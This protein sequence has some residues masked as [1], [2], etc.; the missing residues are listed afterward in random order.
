MK[1]S[2][3]R[4]LSCLL[5]GFL[6][7]LSQVN[8]TPVFADESNLSLT[9]EGP[10]SIILLNQEESR[11]ITAGEDLTLEAGTEIGLRFIPEEGAELSEVLVNGTSQDVASMQ[12]DGL[13]LTM[14]EDRMEISARFSEVMAEDT[15]PEADPAEE[16]SP[17]EPEE[18]EETISA[19]ELKDAELTEAEEITQEEFDTLHQARSVEM[20]EQQDTE[21]L[22]TEA[23]GTKI[24]SINVRWI[25]PQDTTDLMIITPGNNDEFKVRMRLSASLSGTHPYE[26]G[27]ISIA[28]PKVVWRDR[29]GNPT[30][31]M[32]LSVPEAPDTRATFSY[33]ETEDSYI[34]TNTKKLPAAC[35]FYFEF[36][37]QD[38]TPSQIKDLATGYKTDE[39]FG[40][41]TVITDEG[42]VLGMSSNRIQADMDSKAR[43]THAVKRSNNASKTWVS[44]WPAELKPEHEEDYFYVDWYT[45]ASVS[46]NQRYDIYIKDV[47]PEDDPY[48]TVFLGYQVG[49]KVTKGAPSAEDKGVLIQADTFQE[50]GYG[51][52]CHFFMAYPKENFR[53]TGTYPV[54]N[55]VTYSLES[56]DDRETTTASASAQDVFIVRPFPVP[57]GHFDVNKSGVGN[58]YSFAINELLQ[59]TD[60]D[61]EYSVDSIG[62]GMPWTRDSLDSGELTNPDNYGHK[63]YTMTTSDDRVFFNEKINGVYSEQARLTSS[64]DYEFKSLKVN[65]PQI[66]DY[67]EAASNTWGYKESSSSG[68][69]DVVWGAISAGDYGY[70]PYTNDQDV[71]N[72]EIWGKTEMDGELVQYA[73]ISWKDPSSSHAMNG[74]TLSGTTVTF[75]EGVV[76]YEA[77][78]TTTVDAT[79]WNMHPMITLHPTEKVKSQL[80]S[81]YDSEVTPKTTL[82][83][84]AGLDVDTEM[85]DVDTGMDGH[86]LTIRREDNTTTGVDT[87][88]AAA[89]AV[90]PQKTLESQANDT[91][92]QVTHLKYKVT[93]DEQSNLTTMDQ[94]N[95]A[96]GLGLIARRTEGVFYDLL[97]KGVEADT[98]SIQL[99]KGDTITKIS[100]IRDY[101]G[102]GRTLLMVEAK[103]TPQPRYRSKYSSPATA[104]GLEGYCDTLQMT[105][106]AVYSWEDMTVHGRDIINVAGF[107]SCNGGL[108][109]MEGFQG[110]YGN[111]PT[112]GR[113][114]TSRSALAGVE[115]V[116]KDLNSDNDDPAFVFCRAASNIHSD[117][118]AATG[119]TKS[120]SV[121]HD[122]L[123]GSGLD[124]NYPKNVYENGFYT[125]RLRLANDD[126]TTSRN[127]V[128][129]D[130][131]ENWTKLEDRDIGDETWKGTLLSVD[132]SPLRDA[133]V[134]PVVY[135]STQDLELNDSQNTDDLDLADTSK[136]QKLTD[137]TELTAVRC[138]AFDC[139]KA[140]DGGEFVLEPNAAISMYMEM[141]APESRYEDG[142]EYDTFLEEGKTEGEEAGFY[143]G[144]HAYNAASV[145]MS[146]TATG[147]TEPNYVVFTGYTKVGLIPF[148]CEVEKVWED[149]DNRDGKRPESI[150][151]S[152]KEGNREVAQFD[153]NDANS[154]KHVIEKLVPFNKDGTPK[155]WTFEESTGEGKAIDGYSLSITR[156]NIDE[157]GSAGAETETKGVKFVL[158]NTHEPE[159]IR[160]EGDKKWVNDSEGTRPERIK[161]TLLKNGKPDQIKYVTA[162]DNWHYSFDLFKYENGQEIQWEIQE[163]YVPGYVSDVN[164]T[165]V[166]NTWH[167]YGDLKVSK[168]L[169]NATD[170]AAEKGEFTFR[171]ELFRADGTTPEAGTFDYETSDNK[172]G[173]ISPGDTF[174][175]KG[176]E[177]IV[178]R[179]IPSETRYVI[180][181]TRTSGFAL[182]GTVNDKGEIQAGK[183]KE[184]EFTNTYD[185]RGRAI[186]SAVKQVQD[187]SL[188]AG[189]FLFDLKDEDGN[190]LRTAYAKPDGTITFGALSYGLEDA[191][192]IFTYYIQEE[193]NPRPGYILSTDVYKV[194]ITPRDNGDGTMTPEIVYF[195]NDETEQTGQA[196]FTN[197]YK[198]KGETSLAAW[199]QLTGRKLKD[200]EFQFVL[201]DQDGKELQTV[202]SDIN[203]NV[204]FEPLKYTEQ[205]IGK[206]FTYTVEEKAGEDETVNYSTAIYTYRVTVSD[207]KDGTLSMQQ[208]VTDADGE[209]VVPVFYNDLKKGTL[210]VQKTIEGEKDPNQ[211][212]TFRVKITPPEG[213][214]LPEDL[215]FERR[216]LNPSQ[217]E[218][219]EGN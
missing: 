139:R 157:A 83:N 128:I 187:G 92:N 97:P 69:Q 21:S 84:V 32:T 13:D 142:R 154:W 98:S 171:F 41:M 62:F 59:D 61:L 188:P 130:N 14:G 162:A 74:A 104:A 75:P 210:R 145:R 141:Q 82:S 89:L 158:N 107:E 40:D 200:G 1:K 5:A 100:Q 122:G 20:L 215:E 191:G 95:K 36:T 67:R 44:S 76:G 133:G 203:G 43:V 209:T 11:E 12:E 112:A 202:P 129:Y 31:T 2:L 51:Y 159:K 176:G 53:E 96:I 108:G 115:E 207:N 71:A 38:L 80:E 196:V 57:G 194:E 216:Q 147:E 119:L 195:K 169:V 79:I 135:V 212:Y 146:Q 177:Q 49:S 175:L 47:I 160:L 55:T 56:V 27:Q 15:E 137:R 201:K 109:T 204:K 189:A 90:R 167:P 65:K 205:D 219:K 186:V 163:E 8:I 131:L 4:K 153:L 23:D 17:A 199:K 88:N 126:V 106:D 58:P 18:T 30:G 218:N 52:Y 123:F 140:T 105:F 42:T 63:S 29:E 156:Q 25:S 35:S 165:D 9:A 77:R 19:E 68:F 99:R 102:S 34:L 181:E 178:I 16:E 198:A 166:I 37:V 117:V 101:K 64:E 179:H 214:E 185:T 7:I 87:I 134:D 192:K 48:N 172:T 152:M 151:I 114:G 206:T 110:E 150:H 121:N 66:F 46:A 94:Y 81:L 39:F 26:P 125:Y 173:K 182:T 211:E 6:M 54:N 136:W 138:I 217:E 78:T 91:A 120:V 118:S 132:T 113:N 174:T 170:A 168:E 127:I 190:V 213:S 193:Q 161:I 111:D 148:N 72:M 22:P 85:K 70:F 155:I 149:D 60:V 143:G 180:T 33:T 208:D 24:E 103:L 197:I 124:N 28:I 144:T 184:A 164:G 116:M 86:L 93:V 45:Y 73:L 10:G 50:N 3:F 183:L